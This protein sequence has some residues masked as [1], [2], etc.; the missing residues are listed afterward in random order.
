[1][2]LRPLVLSMI[3]L[4][5]FGCAGLIPPATVPADRQAYLDAVRTSWKEQ[6]LSNLVMLHYG[7]PPAFLDITQITTNYTLETN[8]T[9]GYDHNWGGTLGEGGPL[10]VTTLGF[11]RDRVGLSATTKYLSNPVISYVPISGDTVKNILLQPMPV[12]DIFRALETG[13]DPKF[14]L[15][16][17]LQSINHLQNSPDNEAFYRLAEIWGELAKTNAIHVTFETTKE[18]GGLKTEQKG[19]K[20]A[21]AADAIF[22]TLDKNREPERVKTFTQLLGLGTATRFPVDY[23]Y[24]DTPTDKGYKR[25]YV[26]PGSV[27]GALDK[28]S[29]CVHGPQG[30]NGEVDGKLERVHD[31]T[32]KCGWLIRNG[33]AINIIGDTQPPPADTFV[34]IRSKKKWF[35]ISHGDVE[36]KES[37]TS[38]F[39]IL[40]MV[41]SSGGKKEPPAVVLPLR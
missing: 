40:A 16:Y 31:W 25:I 34:A 26:H 27:I 21:P 20:S 30:N 4:T 11:P 39:S 32:K 6:L 14:I 18:P 8:A 13:W 23:G 15:I 7:D 28:A 12:S 41:E 38:L 22:V 37:F 17:C 1:M 2:P 24:P 3:T 29:A 36:S 9:A 5:T 19:T 33:M 35:Y 10:Q